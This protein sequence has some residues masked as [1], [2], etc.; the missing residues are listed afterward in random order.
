MNQF[1]SLDLTT[2]CKFILSS[3][4]YVILTNLT[5]NFGF[6]LQLCI[7]LISILAICFK[8]VFELS[9][10]FDLAKLNHFLNF[11]YYSKLNYDPK[12]LKFSFH[13][14]YLIIGLVSK[15]RYAFSVLSYYYVFAIFIWLFLTTH[16]FNKNDQDS[17]NY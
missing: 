6:L 14:L 12:I 13:L 15:P 8:H 1:R 10:S 2:Y 3:L 5:P 11:F 9:T 16:K 4:N 7:Q 17:K